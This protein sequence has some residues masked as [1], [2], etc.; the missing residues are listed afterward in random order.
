MGAGL[1]W[2]EPEIQVFLYVGAARDM[3]RMHRADFAGDLSVRVLFGATHASS[4]DPCNKNQEFQAIVA[5]PVLSDAVGLWY[6]K[7]FSCRRA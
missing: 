2:C 4:T 7:V 5:S 6:W 3:T 1:S